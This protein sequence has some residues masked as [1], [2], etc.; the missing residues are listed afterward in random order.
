VK[1]YT[2]AV[3]LTIAAFFLAAQFIKPAPPSKVTMATGSE[4]GAYHSFAQSYQRY[5]AAEGVELE[6]IPTAGSVENQ[7]LLR[8]GKVDMALVQS[9]IPDPFGIQLIESMGSVFYEPLW[10][11]TSASRPIGALRELSGLRMAIG[12]EG[13]GTRALATMLLSD[14]GISLDTTQPMGGRSA[15]DALKEGKIDAAF[16]VSAPR[17]LLVQEMLRDQALSV[18]SFDRVQAYAKRY[19]F[20][21]HVVLPQ[22]IVDLQQD[23]PA[24]DKALLAPAA[25]IVAT[26]EIHPAIIDIML[27]AAKQQHGNES[28]FA[29][30]GQFPQ[31]KL[32]AYPLADRAKKFYE[33]GEPV[34]QRY[35]PFWAASLIDR[36]WVMLLPLVLMILPLMKVMPPIYNWR[37]RARVYRWYEKLESI[38]EQ[39]TDA[40]HVTKESLHQSLRDLEQEVRQLKIPL[41][42]AHE[43]YHL[44]QHIELVRQRLL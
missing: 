5:L 1:I 23:I 28:W 19:G 26:K 21:S 3:L 44:R 41:A 35:M 43:A 40:D 37:M 14:N 22:G 9:G 10:V 2:P 17:S 20:L 32:L 25:N 38:D 11:F 13:S 4:S 12:G 6:L 15:Y 34:L 30:N 31:P 36:L 27:M 42:F 24:Q 8:E 7:Q 39:A 33:K 18:M 29:N 16:F